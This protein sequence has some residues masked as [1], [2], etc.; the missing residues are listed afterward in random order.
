MDTNISGSFYLIQARAWELL[1]GSILAINVLPAIKHQYLRNLISIIGLFLIIFSIIFY[2]SN[3][4]FPGF[5]AVIPTIG[6]AMIIYTGIGGESF[7]GR[8]LSCKPIIF[9][10]LISYSLYLWHWPVLVFTRY[11][12]I[13]ALNKA[14]VITILFFVFIL[15]ILSWRFIEKPV[16]EKKKFS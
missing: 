14:H 10:G 9:V 3:T 8:F 13:I 11:Y 1:I 6:A 15:S 5:A 4:K 2:T 12:T 7:V 16:R